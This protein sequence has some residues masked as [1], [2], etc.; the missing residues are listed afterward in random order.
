MLYSCVSRARVCVTVCEVTLV[1]CFILFPRLYFFLVAVLF[2]STPH[3]MSLVV[4]GSIL[5]DGS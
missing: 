2:Y 5:D 3:N 4:T 1:F